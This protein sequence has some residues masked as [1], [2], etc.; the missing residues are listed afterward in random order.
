MKAHFTK[1]LA[2]KREPAAAARSAPRG[3]KPGKAGVYTLQLYKVEF[4][5]P[6]A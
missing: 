6:I 3:G 4:R 1:L 2:A 5:L